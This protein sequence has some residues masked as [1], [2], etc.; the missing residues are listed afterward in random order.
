LIRL[1]LTLSLSSFFL[2]HFKFFFSSLLLPY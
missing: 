2:P 1:S